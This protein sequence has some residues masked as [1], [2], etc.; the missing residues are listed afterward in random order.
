MVSSFVDFLSNVRPCRIIGQFGGAGGCGAA[1][2]GAIIAFPD[3]HEGLTRDLYARSF[4]RRT[5]QVK[6]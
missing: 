4:L 3:C 1:P 2:T 5:D 6:P